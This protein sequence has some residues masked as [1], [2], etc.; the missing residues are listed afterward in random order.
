MSDKNSL[1]EFPTDET[2]EKVQWTKGHRE[3]D[4]LCLGRKSEVWSTCMVRRHYVNIRRF[5]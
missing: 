4:S 2:K 1:L 3:P 5:P